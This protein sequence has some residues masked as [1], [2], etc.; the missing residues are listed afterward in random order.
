MTELIPTAVSC[1]VSTSFIQRMEEDNGKN[2]PMIVEDNNQGHSLL[3]LITHPAPGL[4]L[5]SCVLLGC[6]LSSFAHR[7]QDE[8]RYQ[9]AILIWLAIW[10]AALGKSIGAS[11]NMITLAFI[12]WALCAAMPLSL[13]GHAVLRRVG[14]RKKMGTTCVAYAS[15]VS[16]DE[17]LLSSG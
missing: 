15:G 14:G 4:M 9:A 11:A 6:C 7:R 16:S 8:D 12:P 10:G 1:V 2:G 5:G 17:K 13:L 3:V